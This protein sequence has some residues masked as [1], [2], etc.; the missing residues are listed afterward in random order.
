MS[1][2]SEAQA[3]RVKAAQQWRELVHAAAS[4]DEPSLAAVSKVAAA[5]GIADAVAKLR[6]DADIVRQHARAVADLAQADA[7][8]AQVLEPYGSDENFRRA[9]EAAEALAGELRGAYLA[10]EQGHCITRGFASGT[11][12]RLEG[13]RPDLLAN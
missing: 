13:S 7:N 1:L 3:V 12:R 2:E 8:I 5:L 10:Y 4:G 11:I 9:V 6:D